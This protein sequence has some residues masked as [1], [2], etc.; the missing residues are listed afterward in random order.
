MVSLSS[1]HGFSLH[2]ATIARPGVLWGA[3][4]HGEQYQRWQQVT[5]N[6]KARQLGVMATT[7]VPS[8]N[9]G[10]SLQVNLVPFSGDDTF[11]DLPGGFAFLVHHV[12]VIKLF[13]AGPAFRRMGALVAA[14]QALVAHA[15]AV[16]I[17][18]LLVDHALN[19]GRQFIGMRLKRI[20]IFRPQQGL[21]RQKRRQFLFLFGWCQVVSGNPARLSL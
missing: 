4:R 14:V 10:C 19:L 13:Q 8:V 12:A 7:I 5:Y 15:V 16:A 3:P 17:A 1:F 20:L 21:S 2:R 18:G 6:R 9:R 11:A